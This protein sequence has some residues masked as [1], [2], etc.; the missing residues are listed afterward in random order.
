MA[1]LNLCKFDVN[2]H[3]TASSCSWRVYSIYSTASVPFAGDIDELLPGD[4]AGASAL[5]LL[6]YHLQGLLL[7]HHTSTPIHTKIVVM[8]GHLTLA[9]YFLYPQW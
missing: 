8:I 5:Q 9:S 4:Q 3:W 2:G 7:T 6:R 1:L